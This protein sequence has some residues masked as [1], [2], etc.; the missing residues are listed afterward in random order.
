MKPF[1]NVKSWQRDRLRHERRLNYM[2]EYPYQLGRVQ[3]IASHTQL[4]ASMRHNQ[5]NTSRSHYLNRRK[6]P[7]PIKLPVNPRSRVVYSK[8]ITIKGKRF[9]LDISTDHR[10]LWLVLVDETPERYT[11]ELEY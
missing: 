6:K 9:V 11:L 7:S 8:Q 4:N 3:R 5:L 10:Y 2:C 1:C